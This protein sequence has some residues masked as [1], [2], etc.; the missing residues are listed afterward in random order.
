MPTFRYRVRD[1]QARLYEGTIEAE[2][3]EAVARRLRA[4]GYLVVGIFRPETQQGARAQVRQRGVPAPA[5]GAAPRGPGAGVAR[6]PVAVEARRGALRRLSLRELGV[7]TRQLA[8]MLGSGLSLLQALTVMMEETASPRVAAVLGQVRRNVQSG[9]T[10]ARALSECGRAFP[11]MLVH[12][13]EAGEASGKLDEVLGRV[14]TDY[15]RDIDLRQK[16][17]TALTYPAVVTVFAIIAA[18]VM[19]VFVLPRFA[20]VFVMAG[21]ETPL[22]MAVLLAI[23][24]WLRRLWPIVVA[25]LLTAVVG[26]YAVAASRTARERVARV[27]LGLPLVG[28]LLAKMSI[29]AFSRTLASLLGAGVPLLQSLGITERAVASPRLREAVSA[30]QQGVREGAGLSRYLASTGALPAM[31]TQ[32]MAAGEDSGTLEGMLIRVGDFYD[33]EVDYSLKRATALVEPVVIACLGVG[34]AFV[35]ASIILPMFRLVGVL[36]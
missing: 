4:E 3:E 29:V 12:M 10:F 5:P 21:V 35:A 17:Q 9:F 18:A 25:A 24:A 32:M 11:E 16:L 23:S 2:S 14:A 30:A 22:P 31:V 6:R 1:K 20:E 13:V 8:V 26:G 36:R 15:E 19:V 7:V 34:V 33:K 28:P 27:A